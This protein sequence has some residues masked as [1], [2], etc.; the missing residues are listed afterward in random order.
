M[1]RSAASSQP[2]QAN[3]ARATPVD[4]HV[5]ERIRL[6]RMLLGVSQEQ[7]ASSVG[8]TQQQILYYERGSNRL[9]AGTLYSFARSLGVPVGWFFEGL[10]GCVDDP[11]L[12]AS[13]GR[14]DRH[15]TI[16]ALSSHNDGRTQK[17]ARALIHAYQRV[18]SPKDRTTLLDLVTRLAA[19]G[20]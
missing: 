6:R 1:T 11:R 19:T 5:G 13:G 2:L 8:V 10:P 4:A 15:P 14:S 17:E 3:S 9:S 12:R 20:R 7:L 16:D 18:T